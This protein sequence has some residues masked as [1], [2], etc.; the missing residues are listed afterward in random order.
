MQVINGFLL[1]MPLVSTTAKAHEYQA[2][3]WAFV[4]G[5]LFEVGSYLMLVEAL[6]TGHT[7]LFGPE[8]ESLIHEMEGKERNGIDG[9]GENG[10]RRK[11]KERF[12]WM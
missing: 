4:G 1:F 7:Q 10:G 9:D 11:N 6:N 5:T 2:A 3:A 8:V 12:R